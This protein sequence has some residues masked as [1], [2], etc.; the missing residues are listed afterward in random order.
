MSAPNDLVSISQA[1]LN[2]FATQ[3]RDAVGVLGPYIQR[4][5]AGEQVSLQAADESAVRD[6]VGSLTGLEPP[7][8]AS[9]QQPDPNQQPNQPAQQPDPNQQQPVQP[10]PDPAPSSQP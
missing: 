5:I 3:I 9:A 10:P 1:E 8:P 2:G 7:A 4:L 6:A